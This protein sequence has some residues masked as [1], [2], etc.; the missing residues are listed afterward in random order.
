MYYKKKLKWRILCACAIFK[1]LSS[2]CKVFLSSCEFSSRFGFLFKNNI[3]IQSLISATF[4]QTLWRVHWKIPWPVMY[5]KEVHFLVYTGT[6]VLGEFSELQYSCLPVI[7]PRGFLLFF[8]YDRSISQTW[9]ISGKLY[10][11]TKIIYFILSN[12]ETKVLIH[13]WSK[14]LVLHCRI[15]LSIPNSLVH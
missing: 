15:S 6:T 1:W 10:N 3:S 7:K 14:T 5:T 2:T 8:A 12:F 13:Q 4:P 11:A 9:Y